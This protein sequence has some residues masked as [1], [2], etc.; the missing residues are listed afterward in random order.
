VRARCARIFHWS[1]FAAAVVIIVLADN[2]F[3][4]Y[5]CALSVAVSMLPR[6]LSYLAVAAL[7]LIVV[8]S[9]LTL[10][11]TLSEYSIDNGVLGRALSAG[12]VLMDFDLADWWGSGNGSASAFDSGYAYT[13]G[14]IG[15][16]GAVGLWLLFISLKS[17][18]PQFQQFR[19]LTALYLGMI[20][21]VSYSPYTI[22]TGGLLWFLFGA[23]YASQEKFAISPPT[24]AEPK[25]AR[26]LVEEA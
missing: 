22:K 20:L 9:L 5:L 15:I 17:A 4:A 1:I 25:A 8:V 16:P 13:I 7:P 2:R 24:I 14:Q 11:T 18:N 12:R 19:T 6:R 3:G 23:L 10:A 21:A 26:M